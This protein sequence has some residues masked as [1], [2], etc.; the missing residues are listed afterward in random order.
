MRS[1]LR[2][3]PGI[4]VGSTTCLRRPG[5]GDGHA[6]AGTTSSTCI[7]GN[8]LFLTAFD[9]GKLWTVAYDCR[10]GH[11]LWRKE[12]PAKEIE[13]FQPDVVIVDP[14]TSLMELGTIS[15]GKGMVTRLIDYLKAGQVTSLFTSLTQG[16]HALQQSEG[17]MSS[18]MDSWLLL[19]DFEGNGERNRVLYVLKSR[20]MPHSDEVRN[21]RFTSRGIELE[22]AQANRPAPRKKVRRARVSRGH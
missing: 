11:E 15:E 7:S 3:S 18:L 5:S 10:D 1:T 20:G 2:S 13:K 17:G 22:P 9:G 6:K 19:Q 4:A 12:A 8:H 21:F 16:G 14:I